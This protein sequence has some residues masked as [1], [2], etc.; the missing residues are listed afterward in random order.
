MALITCGRCGQQAADSAT[1]CVH[2]DGRSPASSDWVFCPNCILC[3]ALPLD[4]RP[5]LRSECPDCA[6]PDCTGAERH[7]ASELAARKRIG[8]NYQPCA[9]CGSL[10]TPVGTEACPDC[11]AARVRIPG[12]GTGSGE[13]CERCGFREKWHSGHDSPIQR[14]TRELRSARMIEVL[15][16]Y[17]SDRVFCFW[18]HRLRPSQKPFSDSGNK[19]PSETRQRKADADAAKAKISAAAEDAIRKG[20]ERARARRAEAVDSA[21][22][23]LMLAVGILAVF[24]L[25]TFSAWSSAGW[26]QPSNEFP[27]VLLHPIILLFQ[28]FTM[29]LLGPALIA[30]SVVGVVKA[31]HGVVQAKKEYPEVL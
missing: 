26:S 20:K 9:K 13:V 30:M 7:E 3:G 11:G 31:T 28:M 10:L 19:R 17:H 2:C 16:H 27:W 12:N 24:G 18:L 29:Y 6:A 15:G 23:R 1:R 21:V 25:M 14:R 8:P 4:P 22:T 5:G